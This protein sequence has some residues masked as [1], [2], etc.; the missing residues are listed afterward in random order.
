M[1]PQYDGRK[2]KIVGLD[3]V[4]LAMPPGG[5]GEARAFYVG[6]L[7]MAERPKPPALAQN[8][9]VWFEVPGAVVHLGLE[10]DFRPAQ[11]AHPAL[12][13]ADLDECRRTLLAAGC[14]ARD[15]D[16]LPSVRR[17]Y[18]DDP[19]GNRIEILQAGDGFSERD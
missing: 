7:G 4:Q 14:E 11:K 8:G 15:D 5:E 16:R 2:M 9:G 6:V 17:L 3:H 1:G 12:L 18:T 10:A 19:F 13:V